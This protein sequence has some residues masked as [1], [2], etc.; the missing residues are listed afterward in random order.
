VVGAGD[1]FMS[2]FV[3]YILSDKTVDQA[4]NFANKCSSE[5]VKR[6]GVT[7]LGDIIN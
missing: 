4:I 2:A 1:T 6:R 5:A 7:L 3:T